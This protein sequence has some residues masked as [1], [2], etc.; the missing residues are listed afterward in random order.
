MLMLMPLGG[1]G[2]SYR[3]L[4]PGS[5]AQ[6]RHDCNVVFVATVA[7]GGI[8]VEKILVE[9]SISP[10]WPLE[11]ATYHVTFRTESVIKGKRTD[12]LMA[13]SHLNVD[14]EHLPV[15]VPDGLAPALVPRLYPGFQ[16][17]VG[18]QFELFGHVYGLTIMPVEQPEPIL[19]ALR[20][21]AVGHG[22]SFLSRETFLP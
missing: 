16:Y 17:W 1:C 8:S 4:T 13:I 3:M 20:R 2:Q 12:S 11:S 10:G 5:G 21:W 19:H 7:S 6:L 18:Y 22:R 15:R 9:E 14:N